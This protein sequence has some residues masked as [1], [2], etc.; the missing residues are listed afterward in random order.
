M[1][2]HSDLEHIVIVFLAAVLVVSLFKKLNFSP[3][4][5]YLAAGIIIGPYGLAI[6]QDLTIAQF[7]AE[8]GV[9]FLL[10][11]IGLELTLQRLVS[12]RG[13]VFGL[14]TAQV[15][16]TAILIAALLKFANIPAA[17]AII[18]GGGLAL[19]ST[20]VVLRVLSE[21][22]EQS[23]QVGRLATAILILQD[24]AV[25]PLLVFVTALT[26]E[27]ISLFEALGSAFVKACI[28]LVV[29]FIAG[30]LLLRPLFKV[31][32]SLNSDELFAATTL[33]VVLGAAWATEYAGLTLAL[34]AFLA[35]LMVAE[36]EF[37]HQVEADVLPFKHLLL[38]LFFMTVGMSIDITFLREKWPSIL[39]FS[40]ALLSIKS[41]IIFGLCRISRIALASS[42][43][44][45]LLL[46]QGGEFAFI[47]FSLATQVKVI[48]SDIGQMLLVTVATTMAVTPMLHTLGSKLARKLEN[49]YNQKVM[50][51]E[52]EMRDLHG[53]IIIAGFG[54]VGRTLANLFN[55]ENVNY[56]ALDTDP[57]EVYD[58]RKDG[59]P[60]YYGDAS[61][62]EVLNSVGIF[63][64]HSIITTISEKNK[65]THAVAA[66]RSHFPEAL[67]ISRAWNPEHAKEL[68]HIGASVAI[69][70]AFEAGLQLGAAALS[71]FGV[72][73]HE[74][75]RVTQDFR[76]N[77]DVRVCDLVSP[78]TSKAITT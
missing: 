28:A 78:A 9:V 26:Q 50:P 16:I 37:R 29:I 60:V 33:L 51:S 70:E 30:R 38:G 61:N 71:A 53:H 64:A 48:P 34:G 22:G 39:A 42:V 36:T 32:A 55:A 10:F 52:E 13:Q 75:E 68:Y 62:I 1:E 77:N 43:H 49:K 19:S 76:N 4:L 59:F 12:M 2:T 17:S 74:I 65:C 18:I 23:T 41:A 69:Q 14:G 11:Y 67:I 63:H 66:I 27:N 6:I 73:D 24:L 21:K 47:L 57:K 5:G 25:V 3:V 45:G 46:A 54:R 40:I 15:I 58:G 56:I 44:A 7:I 31:I 20:A 72:A 8:F 35:G